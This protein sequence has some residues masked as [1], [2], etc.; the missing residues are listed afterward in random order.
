[1]ASGFFHIKINSGEDNK[2]FGFYSLLA[3]GASIICLE[4]DE[5]IVPEEAIEKLNEKDINYG[6]V[7][8][9]KKEMANKEKSKN[10]DATKT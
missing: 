4:D 5:Y 7:T 3:S 1:M 9:N 6:I 10:Q 2:D 8:K